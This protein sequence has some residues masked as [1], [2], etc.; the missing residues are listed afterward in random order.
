MR[1]WQYGFLDTAPALD[2]YASQRTDSYTMAPGP[3]PRVGAQD[4]V[5]ADRGLGQP[6]PGVGMDRRTIRGVVP[7][8]GSAFAAQPRLDPIGMAPPE[9]IAVGRQI[10]FGTPQVD[11]VVRGRI[12]VKRFA[13]AM[14]S[15]KGLALDRTFRP[16]GIEVENLGLEQ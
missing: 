5:W 11:P 15:G 12:A 9:N 7:K 1:H 10:V 13:G 3:M 14:R 2:C 4:D 16:A 6:R 8:R